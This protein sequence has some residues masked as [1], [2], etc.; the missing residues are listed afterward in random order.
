M[1][2]IA[3]LSEPKKRCIPGGIPQNL[4]VETADLRGVFG[5]D[6]DAV[7]VEKAQGRIALAGFGRVKAYQSGTAVLAWNARRACWRAKMGSAS[8]LAI[9]RLSTL[10]QRYIAAT[11][12]RVVPGRCPICPPVS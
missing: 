6:P 10:S 11:L 1:L 8:W 3:K 7:S 9:G 4:G 12:S 5:A 2:I